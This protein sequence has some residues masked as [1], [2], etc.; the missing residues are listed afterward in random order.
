MDNVTI[1]PLVAAWGK[2][3]G[4]WLAT[5]LATLRAVYQIHQAAHWQVRGMTAYGDHLLFQRLYEAM[6]KE[7]DDVAERAVGSG[8]PSLVDPILQA[9]QTTQVVTMLRGDTRRV[10]QAEDLVGIGLE[11]EEFLLDMLDAL[12][13]QEWPQGTQ[14]LLQGIADTHES[15][16]YLLSQ[17][18]GL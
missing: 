16:V 11:S 4:A 5:L 2:S 15:H 7:V 8:D 10:V 6:L 18:M 3:Q 17:R 13:A 1:Q 9:S 12:L 14:N